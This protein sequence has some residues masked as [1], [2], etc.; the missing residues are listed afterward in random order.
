[1]VIMM[2]C[3]VAAC[4]VALWWTATLIKDKLTRLCE[5]KRSRKGLRDAAV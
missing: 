5:K 3:F 4:F 2:A 1:M